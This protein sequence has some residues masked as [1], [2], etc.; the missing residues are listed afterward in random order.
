MWHGTADA[1]VNSANAD[2]ILAQWLSVHGLDDLPTATDMVAGHRHRTWHDAAGRPVLEDYRIANV[3]H[4]TPLATT[5]EDACGHAMP[6]MLEAGISSTRRIAASWHLLDDVA[7]DAVA[8]PTG[9]S[10]EAVPDLPSIRT[11]R[12]ERMPT[13]ETPSPETAKSG[14]QKIIEDALRTAGLMR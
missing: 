8:S 11:G 5:G 4:G 10:R 12:L 2:A 1:T 7:D 13:A 9:D 14:V 3:G 6:H